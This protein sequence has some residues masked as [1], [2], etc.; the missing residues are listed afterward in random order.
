M[1]DAVTHPT[2]PR[3]L[4][5]CVAAVLTPVSIIAVAMGADDPWWPKMTVLIYAFG[6]PTATFL[7][8]V[9]ALPAYCALRT[10][11]RLRWWNAAFA[12]AALPL[13]LLNLRS[14]VDFESAGDVVTVQGG[15]YTAI[16]W[17]Y[18]LR[19]L[20]AGGLVG[21]TG[22]L[23]FWAVLALGHRRA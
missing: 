19:G 20:G 21:A 9:L 12:V 18:M 11:W 10:R 8:L 5:A 23:A 2:G 7:L 6:I 13:A 14:S 22:G 3:L 17:S 16:G 1:Q 15:H 4:M